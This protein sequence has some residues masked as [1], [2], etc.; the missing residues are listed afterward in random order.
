MKRPEQLLSDFLKEN[1][2]TIAFA[3]SMTC[4]LIA[5]KLGTISGT[6]DILRGCIVCYSEKVKTD[7]V[8]VKQNLIEQ[9]T[10]ESQQVTDALALNL[11]KLI[12]AHIHVAITGLAAEGGSETKSKPVGTVFYSILFK[13]KLHKTKKQFMGSPL[14]IKEKA[15]AELF[16]LIIKKIKS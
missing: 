7:L 15:C 10:A 2:L 4:G 8:K 16:K 5:H 11:R 1:N 9:Y 12:P 6:A 14:E 3:E 13:D